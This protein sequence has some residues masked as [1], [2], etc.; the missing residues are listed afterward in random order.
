MESI[1]VMNNRLDI[2]KITDKLVLT[3]KDRKPIYLLILV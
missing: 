2:K 1:I 3:I